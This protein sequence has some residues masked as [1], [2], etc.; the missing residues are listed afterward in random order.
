M[1]RI[2][3]SLVILSALA[4]FLAPRALYTTSP[5]PPIKKTGAPGEGLCTDCH[6][7]GSGTGNVAITFSGPGDK[8]IPEE[9]YQVTVK[10]NDS[11]QMRYGFSAIA[12]DQVDSMAGTFVPINF[13]NTSLQS[14]ATFTK[15]YIGHANATTS[16]SWTFDWTAP[17]ASQGA[18]QVTFYAAGNAANGN[19]ANTGDNIYTA[20]RTVTLSAVGMP[21][22]SNAEP[23]LWYSGDKLY[24]SWASPVKE[25]SVYAI[26]DIS[27]KLLSRGMTGTDQNDVIDVS[28]LP[29]GIF[30]MDLD[31]DGQRTSLK[32]CRQ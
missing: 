31:T 24:L 21:E 8:F 19:F 17:P 26:Y 23:E 7:G 29:S 25:Q 3:L 32:F 22:V 20:S 16:S 4:L 6:M 10:V 5:Q 27:G 12:F 28:G 1:K 15:F 18:T 2:L 14:N 13:G 9:T 30:I 11:G